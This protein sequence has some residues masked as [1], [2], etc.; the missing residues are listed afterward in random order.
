MELQIAS[1]NVRGIGDQ[2]KGKEI[3]SCLRAKKFSIYLIQEV[4]C[5]ENITSIGSA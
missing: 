1:L 5:T 2:Q 3:I 4:H